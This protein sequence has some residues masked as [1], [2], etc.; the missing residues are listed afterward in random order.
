MAFGYGSHSN[1]PATHSDETLC[2]HVYPYIL[3]EKFLPI[4]PV[5]KAG[6]W[7][8]NWEREMWAEGLPGGGIKGADKYSF[9]TS[10]SKSTKTRMGRHG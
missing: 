8:K 3:L 7:G 5:L 1:R 9:Y 2:S 6:L 4:S 10:K